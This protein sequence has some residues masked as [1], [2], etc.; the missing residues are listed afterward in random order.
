MTLKGS[1]RN[2][3]SNSPCLCREIRSPSLLFYLRAPRSAPLRLP[4][5]CLSAA[6]PPDV[7]LVCFAFLCRGAGS[8]VLSASFSLSRLLGVFEFLPPEL[9]R[10]LGGCYQ[11]NRLV[12]ALVTHQR[13]RRPSRRPGALSRH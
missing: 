6:S 8:P 9:R 3:Y 7:S 13:F 5:L 2:Y 4:P 1:D 10:L 12:G 11:P